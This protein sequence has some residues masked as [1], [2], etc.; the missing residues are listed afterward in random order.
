MRFRNILKRIRSKA[1]AN[2]K[3]KSQ[4]QK[5]SETKPTQNITNQNQNITDPKNFE[6]DPNPKHCESEPKILRIQTMRNGAEAKRLQT[7]TENLRIQKI[8]KWIP[9]EKL[10]IRNTNFADL[11]KI[12]RVANAKNCEAEL[13]I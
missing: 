13:R 2:P 1:I 7:R 9:V 12:T 10:R 4:Q 5:H 11:K 6:M 8:Q 3:Q